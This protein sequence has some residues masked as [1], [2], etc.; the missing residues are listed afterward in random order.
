V[1]RAATRIFEF[2]DSGSTIFIVLLLMLGFFL[3]FLV[4]ERM[5][6]LRGAPGGTIAPGARSGHKADKAVV[7]DA[8]GAFMRLPSREARE[9][10]LAQCRTAPDPFALFLRR[11]LSHAAGPVA[12]QR[13]RLRLAEV[14][15]L[16]E[17][18]RG[19]ATIRAL[20]N[21]VVLVGLLAAVSAIAGTLRAVAQEGASRPISAAVAPGTLLAVAAAAA[22]ALVA[23]VGAGS[24]SRR[25]KLVSDEIRLAR[26]RLDQVVQGALP[27]VLP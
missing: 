7:E 9:S 5:V 25:A 19:I 21:A 2:L 22:I 4:I 3:C 10:L 13:L 24:V 14:R 23:W 16:G 8:L 27:E 18:G 17:V 1:N 12:T 11:G 26:R 15:G 20:L 6:S